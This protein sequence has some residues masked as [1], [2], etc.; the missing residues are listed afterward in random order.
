VVSLIEKPVDLSL[1]VMNSFGETQVVRAS[2]CP[3]QSA[4]M[5]YSKA[6]YHRTAPYRSLVTPQNYAALLYTDHRWRSTRSC[7]GRVRSPALFDIFGRVYADSFAMSSGA[8]ISNESLV[9]LLSEHD[10][11]EANSE[12]SAK[13]PLP[14]VQRPPRLTRAAR[15]SKVAVRPTPATRIARKQPFSPWRV[16][17]G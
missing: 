7:R 17:A 11:F 3:V 10:R 12:L 15:S 4:M 6:G 1:R 13:G 9:L 14:A 8:V 2:S 16:S 5:W